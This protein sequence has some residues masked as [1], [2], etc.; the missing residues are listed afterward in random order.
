MMIRI[1]PV[2]LHPPAL[3]TMTKTPQPTAT[4]SRPIERRRSLTRVFTTDSVTVC[5]WLMPVA[6]YWRASS[7][8]SLGSADG[9][10]EATPATWVVSPVGL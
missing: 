1:P 8:G 9:W 3:V 4:L 7:A 10:I 5:A 2:R 6:P